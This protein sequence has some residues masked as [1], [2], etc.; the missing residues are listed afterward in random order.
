MTSSGASAKRP[1]SFSRKA[2]EMNRITENI[3]SAATA[4]L[5]GF[6]GG[7]QWYGKE[8][9]NIP[10]E[11]LPNPKIVQP[12]ADVEKPPAAAP[13][14]VKPSAVQPHHAAHAQVP[15]AVCPEPEP[16]SRA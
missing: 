8:P 15:Q 5:I 13:P 4:L 6:Y 10:A 11:P 9:A 2:N 1:L 7:T 12:V 14:P 3:L 16:A